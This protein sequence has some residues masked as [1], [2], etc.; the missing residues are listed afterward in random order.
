M[1]GF[2]TPNSKSQNIPGTDGFNSDPAVAAD[3]NGNALA[4]W[5]YA[6]S[7][8]L[9]N[10]LTP[11]EFYTDNQTQIIINALNESDINFSYYNGTQWSIAAT[12][13]SGQS[14]T[15]SNVTVAY[16]AMS[17]SYIAAWLNTQQPTDSSGEPTTTI[18]WASYDPIL[19][20]WSSVN[21]VLS[22]STPD[23]LT[24]LVISSVNGN[25]ALFW[26]ETQ[27]I[28]YSQLTTQNN[29]E[30]YF[31]L[32]ELAGTTAQNQG[33]LGS[34]ANGTYNGSFTLKEAG[35]LFDS[36]DNSGDPNPAVLFSNGGSM[37]IG[38]ALLTSGGSAFSVEFWFN[39][40]E[41]VTA[42]N[43]LVDLDGVF[44][45]ALNEDNGNTT[46]TFSLDNTTGSTIATSSSS[47]PIDINTWYYVVGT[48]SNQTQEL[49]LYLDGQQVGTLGGVSF[50]TPANATFTIAGGTNDIVLDEVA[51]YSNVLSYSPTPPSNTTNSLDLL[52]IIFNT[53]QIGEKYAAQYVAPLPPGPQAQVSFLN[54]AGTQWT[55]QSQ[56]NPLPFFQPTTLSDANSTMV[57]VVSSTTPNSTG[58][59]SPN[60]QQDT[61][62]R[63]NNPSSGISGFQGKTI[64]SITLDLS[65]GITY[66]VGIPNTSNYQ[67]GVVIGNSL[68]NS[69][70]PNETFSYPIMGSELVLDL[71][72][73]TGSNPSASITVNDFTIT[74]TD[75][76][77][78]T[79]STD[80]K[81][82][83]DLTAPTFIPP[84]SVPVTAGNEPVLGTATVTE[85]E[86]SSLSLIDSGLVINTTNPAMGYAVAS[87]DFN[88]D[89]R[90]DVAVGN[91][92]YTT[93]S[94][95]NLNNG[96]VQIL[97]GGQPVLNGPG[98]PLSPPTSTDTSSDAS[99]NTGGFA[100]VGIP[101][102]GQ[103][104][105]DSALS[106]TTG[107]VNNDN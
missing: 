71:L 23:P 98:G 52:N 10:L 32:G 1:A 29:P 40:P 47:N 62:F 78:A 93:S 88:N 18:Y 68:I 59:I 20:S 94:G 91:R 82:V 96:T 73:D 3:S 46:L 31:R 102:S 25:T 33:I 79:F 30:L 85:V 99:G 57:D 106:L 4:V 92:G 76:T 36:S 103:A 43:N 39:I 11:G 42:T 65:N 74:F 5:V 105:G 37:T 22:E 80:P 49:S 72:V 38:G 34:M 35:A 69:T 28:S 51:V 53:D 84:N 15:D 24:D 75:G 81:V 107:D 12:L 58:N 97:M 60:G 21:T 45:V 17:Q 64:E 56:V 13:G 7:S 83:S 41:A 89:G 100:I 2:N 9:V 6:D 77:I 63:T 8:D 87:A 67:L 55:A 54:S 86:D 48:Y 27:P 95:A 61:I 26:T 101:D 19:Q 14:G 104:N 66:S 16:D 90:S 50:T 70:A 44:S